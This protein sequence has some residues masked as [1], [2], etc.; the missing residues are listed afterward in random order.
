[1]LSTGGAW[2]ETRAG[3]AGPV[4]PPDCTPCGA[5]FSND[6]QPPLPSSL[7]HR[8]REGSLPRLCRAELNHF[9]VQA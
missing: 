3:V 5:Y 7:R 9:P 8:L 4:T 6:L 1:M 2:A